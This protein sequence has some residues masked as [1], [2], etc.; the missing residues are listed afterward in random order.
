MYYNV[1]FYNTTLTSIFHLGL[2]KESNPTII[3]PL[4]QNLK[5]SL[6]FL[7]KNSGINVAAAQSESQFHKTKCLNLVPERGST[8]K[9][10][11]TS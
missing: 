10:S 8:S 3:I 7:N 4:P 2:L 11:A 6:K 1:F 5:A 9:E